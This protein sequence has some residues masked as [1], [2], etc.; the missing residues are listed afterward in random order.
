MFAGMFTARRKK[1]NNKDTKRLSLLVIL[2]ICAP[3]YVQEVV[4]DR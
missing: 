3:Q 4:S 1:T 2:F